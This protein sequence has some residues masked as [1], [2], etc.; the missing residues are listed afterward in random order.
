MKR[1]I[2]IDLRKPRVELLSWSRSWS[3]RRRGRSG[4]VDL[5]RGNGKDVEVVDLE[6]DRAVFGSPFAD[7]GRYHNDN[8]VDVRN[9]VAVAPGRL[10]GF[11]DDGVVL[12]D[13]RDGDRRRC[14]DGIELY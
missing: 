8:L 9:V 13:T 7:G 2:E 3:A 5:R 4:R 11:L 1:L 6:F 10:D 14:G 12:D